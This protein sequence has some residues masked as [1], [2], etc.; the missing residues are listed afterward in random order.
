[1]GFL[2]GACALASE[3]DDNHNTDDILVEV[4]MQGES[5]WHAEGE[6]VTG[7]VYALHDKGEPGSETPTTHLELADFLTTD[8]SDP[9]QDPTFVGFVEAPVLLKNADSFFSCTWVL[10]GGGH[11]P[12]LPLWDSVGGPV[13]WMPSNVACNK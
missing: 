7:T 10:H 6:V 2:T 11:A 4:I 9:T 1:M 3:G 12:A 13:V 5:T 8:E